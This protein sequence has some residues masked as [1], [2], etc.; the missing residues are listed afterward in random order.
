MTS[1]PRTTTAKMSRGFYERIKTWGGATRMTKNSTPANSFIV[2]VT[3]TI[4]SIGVSL[5]LANRFPSPYQYV[6]GLLSELLVVLLSLGV[7]VYEI[8]SSVLRAIQDRDILVAAED[9]A[10]RSGD[11]GFANRLNNVRNQLTELAKGHYELD[12]LYAVYRD[13]I[14]SIKNL[15]KGQQL[16]SMCPVGG[17]PDDVALQ[18]S[19]KSFHASMAEHCNAAD[20]KGV[21]VTRIY[22]F[23]RQSI[24]TSTQECTAHLKSISNTHVDVRLIFLDDP[25][26]QHARSLPRDF[27]IFGNNKVSVGRIGKNSRVD[28]ADVW[29]DK[30]KIDQYRNKFVELLTQSDKYKAQSNT[31]GISEQHGGFR[32]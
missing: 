1:K 18:F 32:C 11:P 17:S 4:V 16:C 15:T 20:N 31:A 7:L 22:I 30:D 28:G 2:L 26:F 8:N 24:L 21:T 27:I 5:L 25:R 23:E 14:E 13:D 19:N 29:A 12:D 6:L 9:S 10:A 3:G